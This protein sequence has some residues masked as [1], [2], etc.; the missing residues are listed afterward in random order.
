MTSMPD[1]VKA[2][3]RPAAAAKAPSQTGDAPADGPQD[4]DF[5]GLLDEAAG[6]ADTGDADMGDGAP[7]TGATKGRPKAP[8]PD[9]T[10]Q[11]VTADPIPPLMPWLTPPVQ[12]MPPTGGMD[13][14]TASALP[15]AAGAAAGLIPQAGSPAGA[16]PA[17]GAAAPDGGV[18]GATPTG[19]LL[20][21]AVMAGQ[22]AGTAP[23]ATTPTPPPAATPAGTALADATPAAALPDISGAAQP[24]A[25]T[26]VLPAQTPVAAAQTP[27]PS[28]PAP[29]AERPAPEKPDTEAPVAVEP[30][31]QGRAGRAANATDARQATGGGKPDPTAALAQAIAE[32]AGRDGVAPVKADAPSGPPASMAG[33]SSGGT[34]HTGVD[35]LPTLPAQAAT[36]YAAASAS[37]RAPGPHGPAM[38]QLAGPLVRVA[39]AGG[40]EFHIDLAPAELGRVR[41]IADVSDGQVTLSVQAEHADTLA[42]LRRDLQHLEKA[43]GES[44]LKLDNATLHFSLQGDGQSRGFGAPDQGGGGAQG[45]WRGPAAVAAV[46][47]IPLE[48]AMRPIDGLVDVII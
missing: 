17:T 20:A 13:A 36:Q 41:V 9:T 6:D 10:A 47:D 26:G 27:L 24:V 46:A 31:R 28:L 21:E 38:A 30:R 48:R 39:E 15:T 35:A 12:P 8:K 14:A 1:I 7:R 45:S 25:A 19:P 32:Q 34:A 3:P 23:G 2:P 4:G 18:P 5:A 29:A 16:E 11:A 43:L 44:G 33:G 42:L 37:G 22:S 40:G